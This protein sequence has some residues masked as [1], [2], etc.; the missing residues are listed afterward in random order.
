MG[1]FLSFFERKAYLCVVIAETTLNSVRWNILPLVRSSPLF[2]RNF[3][4]DFLIGFIQSGVV[5]SFYIN[6][7][8]AGGSVTQP[9]ADDG[10]IG[11]AVIGQARPTVTGHIGRQL[12]GNTCQLGEFLQ[13][14]VV[15][16]EPVAILAIGLVGT[17]AGEDGKDIVRV[18]GIVAT[19]YLQGTGRKL[20]AYLLIGLAALVGEIAILVNL[21]LAEKGHIDKGDATGEDAEQEDIAHEL[22]GTARTQGDLL[23]FPDIVHTQGALVGLG[24]AGIAVLEGMEVGHLMFFHG[25]VVDRPKRT[26]VAG[27]GVHADAGGLEPTLITGYQGRGQVL[28]QQVLPFQKTLEGMQSGAIVGSGTETSF[29]PNPGYLSGEIIGQER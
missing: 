8:G 13:L 11:M 29:F 18:A 12:V 2:P 21:R 1:E 28:E 9:F 17:A 5:Y 27:D 14:T 15:I 26:H 20:E 19:D 24:I 6:I 22:K 16:G 25:L 3:I 23:Q 4:H 10:Y 7:S